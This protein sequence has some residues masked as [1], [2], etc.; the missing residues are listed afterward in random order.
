MSF[1]ATDFR[2]YPGERA[3][4]LAEELRRLSGQEGRVRVARDGY[5]GAAREECERP[6]RALV[7]LLVTG[8]RGDCALRQSSYG[9]SFTLI[10][11]GTA[12]VS[13]R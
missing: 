2:M 10:C 4:G 6:S 7:S 5:P 9:V 11:G 1:S 12:R 13:S 8:S 3:S